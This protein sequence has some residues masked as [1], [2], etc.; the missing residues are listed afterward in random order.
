MR[1]FCLRP[2]LPDRFKPAHLIA[3]MRRPSQPFLSRMHVSYKSEIVSYM[4]GPRSFP[5]G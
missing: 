5:F 4:V 3:A 2:E 1:L